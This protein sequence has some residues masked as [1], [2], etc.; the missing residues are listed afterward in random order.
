MKKKLLATVLAAALLLTVLPIGAG[1]ADAAFSMPPMRGTDV[2][3]YIPDA[4]KWMDQGLRLEDWA[5][6]Y[7]ILYWLL[8][9]GAQ[10]VNFV[11]PNL[12]SV[13]ERIARP[14]MDLLYPPLP[15]FV[16]EAEPV[17]VVE[18]PVSLAGYQIF[19]DAGVPT[20]KT[21]AEILR[22]TLNRITGGGYTCTAGMPNGANEFLVGAVSGADIRALG[23]DGYLIE[24]GENGVITIAGG[25]RG[26]LY[27]VHKFL[28]KYFDCRWYTHAL[29][30]IPQ[31]GA[32]IAAVERESYVPALEYRETDWLYPWT[33]AYN[34]YSIAN[35][36]NGNSYRSI[37][38]EQGGTFGYDGSFAHT[39][40]NW[41]LRPE[42]HYDEH[43]E[44]YAWREE[45]KRREP[46]QLCLS[47]GDVLTEIKRELR[48]WF[49]LHSNG[50]PI[51]SIT[52]DDNDWFCQCVSCKAIDDAEGSHAG[53]MLRFVNA[54]A[55]EYPDK[56][57]DTF[58]YW[59]TRTPPKLVRPRENVIIRLC[60]IECCFAH[61]LDDPGCAENVKFANDIRTWKEIC[62]N[63]YIW[64]Y[65]TNYAH[66]N[67]V[68]P[69]FD[70][71]Q[72]NMQ[73]FVA[74][75][76]KGVYEEGNYQ[77]YGSDSEFAHLRAYLLARLM[78]DPD[79]DYDAEMNG[80]LK[81][82][83]G[84]GWQYMR[85]FIDLTR[86]N[87]GKKSPHNKMG[88]YISPT[89]EDLLRLKPNQVRYADAL[90]AKAIALAGS[91][92]CKQNVLRSQLSWR[93]WKG[94]NRAE[95]FWRLLPEEAWQEANERLFNDFVSFGITIYHEGWQGTRYLF[96]R[97]ANWW[98]TP[99]DW[100]G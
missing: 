13:A 21:A 96:T 3:R 42:D 65:T 38:A 58:A 52:Q 89:D 56:V 91:E 69:N 98:G 88:I 85:E 66:Y 94:A 61:A 72:K 11:W 19:Y 54:I 25:Q 86:A 23:N 60:S 22:D 53:T 70:V 97:P 76:V 24:P 20:D 82:Y 74:N 30:V 68:F 9:P 79:M 39:L 6:G 16:P 95:E 57:F 63:L 15:E 8:W 50:Q 55:A 26:V 59:Y 47:N 36:L 48:E 49:K 51:L 64:D 33:P 73:F 10:L 31:G 34:T 87:A 5:W 78:W 1:A 32:D 12:R 41:F 37:P 28:E 80:F 17:V 18:K 71:M 4:A 100:H 77:A 40:I 81:A 14:I 75:N 93:F 27:G 67:C 83:Y 43:P 92:Q 7:Q 62:D 35:G 44:W 45:T 99:M 29:T 2:F 46:K 84:G 90:W